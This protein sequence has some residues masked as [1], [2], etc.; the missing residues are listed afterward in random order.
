MAV[1][2]RNGTQNSVFRIK[3]DER[4]AADQPGGQEADHDVTT[5]TYSSRCTL[6]GENAGR[7]MATYC[8]PP[9]CG[10]L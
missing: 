10:V 4:D 3:R 9:S 6:S 2:S 7:Q 8:A 5:P 1:D